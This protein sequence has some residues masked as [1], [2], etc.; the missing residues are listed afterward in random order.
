MSGTIALHGGGEYQPGDEAFLD[1]WLATAAWPR[2]EP[3]EPL[4]VAVVPTAAARGRPDLAAA[5]GV[6]A[7]GRAG[8]R[9]GWAVEVAIVPVLDR[10][11]ADDPVH[12]DR[13]ARATAIHLPG[14]DPDLIP[15]VLAGTAV[16]AAIRAAL[17]AGGT[18]AGASAGAMGLATWTW[19]AAGGQ[20]GLDLL[21]GPPLVVMPHADADSWPASLARFGA[22]VPSG[23]GVLGIGER[24]GVLISL[25]TDD[26]WRVAG[27][28]EVRW[29]PAGGDTRAPAVYR[30]GDAFHLGRI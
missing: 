11:S 30:H 10:A 12:V 26:P 8:T 25:G 28:G 22:S 4:R 9:L 29:S 5:N 3:T 19:T 20:A 17:A 27:A 6:A 16:W 21:P 14:G 13:L 7:I 18:L 1:A 24:T 23:V 15:T 2:G